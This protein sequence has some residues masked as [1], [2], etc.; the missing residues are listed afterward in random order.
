[1]EELCSLEVSQ[2]AQIQVVTDLDELTQVLSWFDQFDQTL[3]SH[4]VWLQC[5][6]VLAEG[7]TNAVRHAHKDKPPATPIE[8]EVTQCHSAIEIRIWDCGAGFN[9]D[10]SLKELPNQIAQD[11]EG[12][13]GLSIMKKLSDGLTYTQMPDRRNC[14]VIVKRFSAER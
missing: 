6:L 12:G 2:Q 3:M 11:A 4:E 10:R 9:F 5:Q 7:F 14:L 8:I 1:M 13:R